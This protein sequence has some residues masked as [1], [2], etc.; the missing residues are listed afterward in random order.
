M[1][2]SSERAE[3]EVLLNEE[4]DKG[5][6]MIYSRSNSDQLKWKSSLLQIKEWLNYFECVGSTEQYC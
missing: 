4:R 1:D 2:I 5:N 3:K 6:W